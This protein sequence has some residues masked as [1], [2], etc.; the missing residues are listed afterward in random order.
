MNSKLV[1]KMSITIVTD[2]YGQIGDPINGIAHNRII[3]MYV[4]DYR[5]AI[6]KSKMYNVTGNS[7]VVAKNIKLTDNITAVIYYI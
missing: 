6:I 3:C 5:Y 2:Q 4:W 1:N 7:I